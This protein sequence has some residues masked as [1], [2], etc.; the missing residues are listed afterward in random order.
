MRIKFPID[1]DCDFEVVMA[2]INPELINI[3]YAS[4]EARILYNSLTLDE[5]KEIIDYIN[6]IKS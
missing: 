5:K 6:T 2:L 4:S 3:N 1:N